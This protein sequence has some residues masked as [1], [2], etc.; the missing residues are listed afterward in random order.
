M[1][2]YTI[3]GLNYRN[4]DTLLF[5]KLAGKIGTV[6]ILQGL[7]ADNYFCDYFNVA[8]RVNGRK[9][10]ARKHLIVTEDT[11]DVY[12]DG[13]NQLNLTD[14][15]KKYYTLKRNY[16]SQYLH[17][18]KKDG[19]LDKNERNDLRATLSETVENLKACK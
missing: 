5:D 10:K 8:L 16:L 14:N 9:V 15:D 7:S 12:V 19:Y 1:K 2:D 4:V 3:S 13:S 6:D 11:T 17:D 18:N